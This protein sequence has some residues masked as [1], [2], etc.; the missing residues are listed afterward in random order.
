M[1]DVK[2]G[3]LTLRV[4]IEEVHFNLNQSLKQHDFEKAQ[5]MRVENA[6][7]VSKKHND[8]YMTLDLIEEYILNSLHNENLEKEELKVEAELIET[9]I[10]LNEESGVEGSSNNKVK[11]RDVEKSY[12]GLILKELPKHLKYAFFG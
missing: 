11:E 8:K 2:K 4:G 9:V 5:C 12:E 7:V 3:E 1:I 6:T 10:S